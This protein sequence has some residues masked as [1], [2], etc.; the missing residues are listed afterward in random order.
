MTKIVEE[1]HT[2]LKDKNSP[3]RI[4]VYE[5]GDDIF[6]DVVTIDDDGKI[7]QVFK[8]DISHQELEVLIHQIKSGTGLILDADV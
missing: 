1:T 8:H 3:F 2:E 6:I 7:S 4:C 5:E